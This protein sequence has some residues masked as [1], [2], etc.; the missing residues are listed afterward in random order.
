M[1]SGQGVLSMIY[2]VYT[3]KD[4]EDEDSE[5]FVTEAFT[6]EGALG[7]FL[8]WLPVRGGGLLEIVVVAENEER[9]GFEVQ[10]F[11]GYRTVGTFTPCRR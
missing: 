7:A 5:P 4:Y 6:H 10:T 8:H 3:L 9:H 1:G 11:T 2:E